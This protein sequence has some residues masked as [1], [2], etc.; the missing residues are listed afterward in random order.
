MKL[1]K[2]PVLLGFGDRKIELN[3][4]F[5]CPN[6]GEETCVTTQM[7]ENTAG[8]VMTTCAIYADYAKPINAYRKNPEK[9]K[10]YFDYAA[11]MAIAEHNFGALANPMSLAT[12][13]EL[14]CGHRVPVSISCSIKEVEP[15]KKQE[16][17]HK[18]GLNT[19]NAWRWIS[20]IYTGR[21]NEQYGKRKSEEIM[22]VVNSAQAEKQNLEDFL[23]NITDKI[24]KSMTGY[25]L[26]GEASR[27]IQKILD[28]LETVVTSIIHD[29]DETLA[30]IAM[31]PPGPLT[32]K[33]WVA[34][35]ETS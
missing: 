21:V 23:K 6:C 12:S 15:P 33:G 7:A 22:Y 20:Y 2:I 27:R 13:V 35:G 28:E 1:G 16:V 17:L 34:V 18:L 8:P 11:P 30:R 5:P 10:D 31:R 29:L 9:L 24:P 19:E 4:P 3:K 14:P 32:T 25:D 26:Q